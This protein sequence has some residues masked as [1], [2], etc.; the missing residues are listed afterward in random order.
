MESHEIEL[1]GKTYQ[2]CFPVRTVQAQL[3]Q[4]FH[5]ASGGSYM[6]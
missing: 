1:D 6:M 4:S 3:H 5:T 2:V